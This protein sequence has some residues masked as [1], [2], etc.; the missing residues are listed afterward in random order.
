MMIILGSHFLIIMHQLV[1]VA[2]FGVC[3]KP[4]KALVGGLG[5]CSKQE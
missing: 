3:L 4:E 5:V 1:F 2:G